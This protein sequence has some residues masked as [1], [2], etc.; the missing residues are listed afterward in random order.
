MSS[1][2]WDEN[3]D[4]HLTDDRWSPLMPYAGPMPMEHEPT[5]PGL[6]ARVRKLVFWVVERG[7]S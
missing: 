1:Q 7:D 3:Q 6:V 2:V 5:G 4:Q